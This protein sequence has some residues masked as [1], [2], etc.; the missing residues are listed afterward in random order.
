MTFGFGVYVWACVFVCTCRCIAYGGQ[1]STPAT[2]TSLFFEIGSLYGLGLDQ[3]ASRPWDQ[4][5]SSPLVQRQP[6]SSGS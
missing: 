6:Q 2:G 3:E 4:A 5:V 1:R